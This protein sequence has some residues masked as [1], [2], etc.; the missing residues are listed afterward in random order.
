MLSID[1]AAIEQKIQSIY[2]TKAGFRQAKEQALPARR[3][4]V[5]G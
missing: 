1:D 5:P 4:L 2:A 3:T